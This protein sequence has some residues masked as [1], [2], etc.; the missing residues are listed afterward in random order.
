M[1]PFKPWQVLHLELSQKFSK[2]PLIPEFGG[3]Y[4]VFWWQG[5]PLGDQEILAAQLP[6]PA[7]QLANLAVQTIA[8]AVGDR[9]FS[10]SSKTS[11]LSKLENFQF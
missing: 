10:S 2:L 9:L 8:P 11:K 7:T 4:V 3:L 5:V 1:K 6:M